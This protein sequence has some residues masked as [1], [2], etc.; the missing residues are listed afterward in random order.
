MMQQVAA[1]K[2]KVMKTVLILG[3]TVLLNGSSY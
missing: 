2:V 3:M 1:S